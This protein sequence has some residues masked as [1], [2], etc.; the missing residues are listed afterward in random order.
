MFKLGKDIINRDA[1]SFTDSGTAF[2]EWSQNQL[3]SFYNSTMSQVMITPWDSDN[4][5]DLD[6]VYVQLSLLRDDRKLD[7]TTKKKLK[8]YGEI[9]VGHGRHLTPKRI[10]VYGKP[11]IGKST[12]SKKLAVDWARGENEDLK[13][14]TVLL[15]VRLRD[16]CNTQNLR[17]MLERSELLSG[18]D[19]MVFNQLYDYIL[20]NQEK[21][22]LVL[23][24]YD[25]Y[26]AEKPSPVHQLWRG[27]HLRDCAILVTTR[28]FK[29]D[30]LRVSSHVQ[31]EIEGFDREQVMQFVHKFLSHQKDTIDAFTGFLT[32][33]QLWDMAKIP[34]LLLMLCLTWKEKDRLGLP[35]SRAD[36]YKR[37]FQTLFDHLAAKAS[38]K[39]FTSI[40]EYKDSLSK[41]GRLAFAA[42][43]IDCLYFELSKVPEDIRLL[44]KKFLAVGFFQLSKLSSSPRPEEIVHF[45]HKTVQEFL[46]A[47]FIVQEL[48]VAKKG[49][50]TCLSKVDSFEKIKK[51][52]EV[53]KFVCELS[54][55][56]ASAVL[57]HLQM[58]GQKEGLTEYSFTDNPSVQNDLSKD[59]RKFHLISLDCFLSCPASD[60]QAIYPLF[61]Q[62]VNS[63]VV[64]DC[65][66]QLPIVAKEHVLRL[67]T[68]PK[69]N[70][71][72]VDELFFIKL[73][74]RRND[75]FSIMCDLEPVVVTCYGDTKP[76]NKYMD[77][78]FIIFS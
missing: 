49:H 38:D 69:P 66:H 22:L 25:E 1:F 29:D 2:L 4:T 31:F 5:M 27:S 60:R 40:D 32:E 33:R 43:L 3:C 64:I 16:V 11:G 62:C 59:Q 30:E 39:T 8:D 45:L 71:L 44:I 34:L 53:L 54:S 23:D 78:G 51:M 67:F 57:G 48:T 70:Y 13:K 41:L 35:K 46:S 18:D 50:V 75:V 9:F 58:V 76:V 37:F 26:S 42:L 36:L 63:V 77:L 19:P 15:L 28:P 52:H 65:I 20:Q 72:F 17:A 21:V 24:G 7:G 68:S 14:F 73:E 12:F 10:L 47:W 74:K 55:E 6:E 61:L 56:A